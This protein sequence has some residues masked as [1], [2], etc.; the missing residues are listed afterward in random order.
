[1]KSMT[2][3]LMITAAALAIASGVASAQQYR[4][5]IPFAFRAGGKMMSPGSYA[6]QVK[7]AQHYLVVISNHQARES[8]VL[9]PT[10]REDTPR[11]LTALD[12]PVLTFECG[13]NRCALARIWTGPE[14]PALTFS[15]PA[16]DKDEHASATEIRV[17]KMNGD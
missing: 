5:D 17:V 14:S 15:H 11:G 1:M 8:A 6:V 9:L 2:T 16:L 7:D 3:K 13:S 10:T 12:K 4:A